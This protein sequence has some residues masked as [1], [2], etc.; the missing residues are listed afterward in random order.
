MV[1]NSAQVED[2]TALQARRGAA[3]P[4]QLPL[5]INYHYHYCVN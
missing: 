2:L 4:N 5:Q 3:A 1:S